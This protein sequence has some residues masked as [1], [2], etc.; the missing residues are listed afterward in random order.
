MVGIRAFLICLSAHQQEHVVNI[1]ENIIEM[2]PL[3]KPPAKFSPINPI[4]IVIPVNF[5]LVIKSL[6][7]VLSIQNPSFKTLTGFGW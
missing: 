4:F 2:F 1:C 6:I 5:V 3:E 7:T